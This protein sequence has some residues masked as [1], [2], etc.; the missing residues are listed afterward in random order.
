MGRISTAFMAWCRGWRRFSWR[1]RLFL[2]LIILRIARRTD[3][4][5]PNPIKLAAVNYF[6]WVK[7]AKLG[8]KIIF[9][10]CQGIISTVFFW[11]CLLT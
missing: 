2:F 8:A 11:L 7:T 5:W 6:S 10:F 4:V 1:S 3:F 9:C